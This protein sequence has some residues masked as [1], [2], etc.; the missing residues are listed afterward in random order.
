MESK[1][2]SQITAEGFRLNHGVRYCGSEQD[3]PAHLHSCWE[4]IFFVKGNMTHRVEGKSFRLHRG[5][6][7]VTR[8]SVF[9]QILPEGEEPYER[10]NALIDEE[11]IPAAIAEKIPRG[12]EVFSFGESWRMNELFEK[13]D[14]YIANG[15]GEAVE[16]VVKNA[17]VEVLFM[18]S[19][20]SEYTVGFT[21]ANPLVDKAL[22]YVDENLTTLARVSEI[23]DALYVTKSHLHH[24]FIEHLGVTPKQYVTSKRL[25]LARKLIRRGYSS[26]A[27]ATMVGY[28]DYA[29]FYRNYKKQTGH[30]PSEELTA[31]AYAEEES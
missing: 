2:I 4:L 24:L 16:Q 23:A 28:E 13:M 6:L 20:E 29:T 10:Y 30:S 26:T 19:V 9:H 1:H 15:K 22:D 17:L 14:F 27:A 11:L 21:S 5:D 8:P 7:V 12:V 25:L 3:F 31:E 18:L